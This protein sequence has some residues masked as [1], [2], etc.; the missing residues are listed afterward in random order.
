MVSKSFTLP[1]LRHPPACSSAAELN[2]FTIRASRQMFKLL[3]PKHCRAKSHPYCT[4]ICDLKLML[5]QDAT[6][7]FPT[8]SGIW[9][10]RPSRNAFEIHPPKTVSDKKQKYLNE[11]QKN[12]W[13]LVQIVQL[14]D[15]VLTKT[16]AT[17]NFTPTFNY[18]IKRGCNHEYLLLH[19]RVMDQCTRICS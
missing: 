12:A 7:V 1:A 5:S 4:G 15:Y 9:R 16:F 6:Q 13:C 18:F 11:M 17:L 3:M 8:H 14:V 19:L 10:S 2:P